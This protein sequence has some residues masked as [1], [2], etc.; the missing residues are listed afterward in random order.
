MKSTILTLASLTS[1]AAA[2]T[3]VTWASPVNVVASPGALEKDASASSGW[4]AGAIS[5]QQF[6]SNTQPQGVSFKCAAGSTAMIGLDNANNSPII[7]VY[8]S[9]AGVVNRDDRSPVHGLDDTNV[10]E[11]Y[12]DIAYAIYCDKAAVE[13]L[14]VYEFGVHKGAFG[15]YTPSDVL[16]VQ[17]TGT[18][19]EYL[20]NGAVFYTSATAAT[21]PLHVDTSISAMRSKFSDVTMKSTALTPAPTGAPTA[22]PTIAPATEA[23]TATTCTDTPAS[24]AAAGPSLS[25]EGTSVT[26][27]I[28]LLDDGTTYAVHPLTIITMPIPPPLSLPTSP[29][30][31]VLRFTNAKCLEATLCNTC[32]IGGGGSSAITSQLAEMK[33]QIASNHASLLAAISSLNASQTL[34]EANVAAL[35]TTVAA[36]ANPGSGSSSSSPLPTQPP[37]P[38]LTADEAEAAVQALNP[39]VWYKPDALTSSSWPDAGSCNCPMTAGVDLG[40]N[41][42]TLQTTDFDGTRVP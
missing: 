13:V 30:A 15:T 33:A 42:P 7:G 29:R 16:E 6:T 32:G 9:N 24:T 27:D 18:T 19:V 41:W 23:P 36:A 40:A 10:G 17:V 28:D 20:K 5:T 38:P 37:P 12:Q 22:P 25:M 11:H 8:D 4:N 14:A 31:G 2:D 34:T 1:L 3:L 26:V 21:F 39:Y 35:T